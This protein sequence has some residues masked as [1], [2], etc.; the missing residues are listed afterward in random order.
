MVLKCVKNWKISKL[1][2]KIKKNEIEKYLY[3]ISTNEYNDII[4]TLYRFIGFSRKA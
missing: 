1:L 3:I 2:L 4:I